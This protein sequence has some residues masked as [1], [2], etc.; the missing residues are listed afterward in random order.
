MEFT[1]AE[2]SADEGEGY[3]AVCLFLDI[4]IATPLTVYVEA[5]EVTPTS[6]TGMNVTSLQCVFGHNGPIVKLEV[7]LTLAP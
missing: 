2:Y 7:A 6:A 1:D 5:D 3:V 4:P